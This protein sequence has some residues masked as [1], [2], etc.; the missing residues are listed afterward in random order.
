M[1]AEL[2]KFAYLGWQ[3][4][5]RIARSDFGNVTK[6]YSACILTFK[7]EERELLFGEHEVELLENLLRNF[8]SKGAQLLDDFYREHLRILQTRSNRVV[9]FGPHESA[10]GEGNARRVR[11]PNKTYFFL[12]SH[13]KKL[14]D[15]LCQFINCKVMPL[16]QYPGLDLENL[17]SEAHEAIR[18]DA[19]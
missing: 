10:L 19:I 8:N 18:R 12:E 6:R 7:S 17:A 14:A 15:S 16:R 11:L 9:S 4:L 2:P 13:T 3:M 1:S 5:P